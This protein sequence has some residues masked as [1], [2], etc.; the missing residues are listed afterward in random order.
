MTDVNEE[1]EPDYTVALDKAPTSLQSRFA[2]FLISDEVGY[3]PASAKT[4]E[5]AFREGVRLAVA[6]RI[7][8]QASTTNKEA[9]ELERQERAEQKRLAAEAKEQAKAAKAAEAPAEEEEAPKPAKA[10]KGKTK[11]AP[12][13][14]PAA[15]PAATRPAARR[16]P[17]RR[18]GAAAAPADAPF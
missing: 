13:S 16:A 17:A 1:L 8:F 11:P 12:A 18:A 3:S 2:D 10:V 14:T 5:E 4:K 7:P 15:A 9:T 6:L